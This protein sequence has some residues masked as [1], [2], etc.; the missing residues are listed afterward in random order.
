MALESNR[1]ARVQPP[2]PFTQREV[3]RARR[4][5]RPLYRAMLVDLALGVAL[6]AVLSFGALGDRLYVRLSGLAWWVRTPA[7]TAVVLSIL[8]VVRLPLSYWRSYV[9][10]KQWGL[11]TQALSGWVS[12]RAKGMAVALVLTSGVMLGF[13]G[14]ARAFPEA[15]PAMVAPGG[16]V[17]VLVFSFVVPVVFE[18]IFNRFAPVSDEALA[19]DL[20]ALADRA[21]VPIRDVL[22][23]DASR[24]TNKENAYVSGLG[25]SRRVVLYDTLL[26][27][28]D[29][30]EVSLIVAH[31]LG[32]RR[33][34]HVAHGTVIG[35]A[36]MVVGSLVLWRLLSITAVLHAAGAGGAG[37]PR[38]VPFVLLTGAAMQLAG[39][40]FESALSRRWESAADRFSLELIGDLATFE[41]S[42]RDLA[43]AN[44]IDLDP[45]RIVYRMFFTHPTPQE[46]IA[47]A[48]KWAADGALSLSAEPRRPTTM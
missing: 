7:F 16:A 3:E 14:L 11:S 39:A 22:V 43:T 1:R 21:G 40:P 29:R 2:S 46:R 38:V 24:R 20:R 5:H 33:M 31:E 41:R 18:P 32:H 48:R 44:L 42:H 4:Y 17:L 15:W 19:S 6:L 37:D 13:I 35:M 30:R 34:R 27:A 28:A 36:G 12:D 9:H 45:P 25:P 10:E 8:F 23:A 47:A 26:S